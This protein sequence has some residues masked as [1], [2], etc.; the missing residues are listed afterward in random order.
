MNRKHALILRA[1]RC[2]LALRFK[3]RSPWV[4]RSRLG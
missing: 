4:G 1:S 3:A 2:E